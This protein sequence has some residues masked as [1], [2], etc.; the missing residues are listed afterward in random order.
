MA[1]L[2]SMVGRPRQPTRPRGIGHGT[3]P[4]GFVHELIRRV[5]AVR[6]G[7]GGPVHGARIAGRIRMTLRSRGEP[8]PDRH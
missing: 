2:V 6:A 1:F 3:D 5:T 8:A 7:W 4:R